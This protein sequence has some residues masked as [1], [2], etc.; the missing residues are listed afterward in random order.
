MEGDVARLEMRQR[1]LARSDHLGAA[2]LHRVELGVRGAAARHR[3][4]RQVAGNLPPIVAHHPGVQRRRGEGQPE[5]DARHAEQLGEGAHHHDVVARGGEGGGARRVRPV[6]VGLIDQHYRVGR[7]VLH[8]P[9]DVGKR[10]DYARRIVWAADIVEAGVGIGSE[11]LAHVCAL[12]RRVRHLDERRLQPAGRAPCRLVGRVRGDEPLLRRAEGNDAAHQRIARTGPGEDAVLGHLV[13]GRDGLD[14]LA[15]LVV[16]IVA[17]AAQHDLR[18]GIGARRERPG[19]ALVGADL[20]RAGHRTR[21]LALAEGRPKRGRHR[22]TSADECRHAAELAARVAA[23]EEIV[24]G[25]IV[26]HGSVS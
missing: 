14:E 18:G 1:L 16:W 4:D 11:H 23:A 13:H 25:V 19:P 12:S 26:E 2:R 3:R 22:R 8:Q 17:V 21:R 20:D 24:L 7:L 6:D 9:L 5:A 10:G 15:V